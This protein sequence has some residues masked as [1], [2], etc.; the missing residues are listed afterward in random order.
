MFDG[1]SLLPNSEEGLP[2]SIGGRMPGQSE[3]Q[4][5]GRSEGAGATSCP[6]G[7]GRRPPLESGR[8]V[9]VD[10]LRDDP[11]LRRVGRCSAR[12]PKSR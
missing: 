7:V 12:T 9:V 3:T 2:P 11:A 6:P 1:C 8:C 5:A 4:A 10:Q